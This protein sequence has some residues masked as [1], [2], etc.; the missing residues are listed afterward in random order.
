[1]SFWRVGLHEHNKTHD[2]LD[3]PCATPVIYGSFLVTLIVVGMVGGI[4]FVC[5]RLGARRYQQRRNYSS[6]IKAHHKYEDFW[7][8]RLE[9]AG[10]SV[11][12]LAAFPVFIE[13]TRHEEGN[14]YWLLSSSLD[15]VGMIFICLAF[16]WEETRAEV[17]FGVVGALLLA[18]SDFFAAFSASIIG[19]SNSETLGVVVLWFVSSCVSF[20]GCICLGLCYLDFPCGPRLRLYFELACLVFFSWSGILEISWGFCPVEKSSPNFFGSAG[21]L[22]LIG[23]LLCLGALFS[24]YWPPQ[25]MKCTC[26]GGGKE[27]KDDHLHEE[28]S[29]DTSSDEDTL[30]LGKTD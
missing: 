2:A 7:F 8:T 13:Y 17:P 5:A 29:S 20:T 21:V 12:T 24:E 1:M 22:N 19:L 6:L 30:L 4:S 28:G 16:F 11:L 14:L 23:Y 15:L 18:S 25:S 26:G 27:K 10:L 3:H 9:S